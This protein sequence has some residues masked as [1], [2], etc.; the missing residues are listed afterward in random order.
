MHASQFIIH[1]HIDEY[2][3]DFNSLLLQV[4][5]QRV[6]LSISLRVRIFLWLYSE[7]KIAKTEVYILSNFLENANLIL[8]AVVMTLFLHS[9]LHLES[10]DF[11]N[12]HCRFIL[13]IA[14][15][16]EHF[17]IFGGQKLSF[18]E[19]CRL[20][21]FAYFSYEVV[22]VLYIPF[23]L[24]L[25]YLANVF[26]SVLCLSS[27]CSLCLLSFRNFKIFGLDKFFTY[28]SYELL[29]NSLLYFPFFIILFCFVV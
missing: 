6:S 2:L 11:K 20:I 9:H 23:I 12:C 10:L 3:V 21:M 7:M 24:I 14:N 28:F 1:F 16:S 27:F 15:K 4:I 25:V 17:H 22:G 29:L 8:K 5:S 26:I 18:S 19:N 13:L